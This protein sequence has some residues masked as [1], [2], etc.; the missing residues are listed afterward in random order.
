MIAE[1]ELDT[2]DSEIVEAFRSGNKMVLQQFYKSNYP[3]IAHFVI[4]NGGTDD[5]AKDIYQDA[6]I[7]IYERINERSLILNCRLKTYL[8]SVCRNLWLK[9]IHRKGKFTPHV[10]DT[11]EYIPPQEE[12]INEAEISLHYT[13]ISMAMLEIGEPCQSLLNG[14]YIHQLSMAEITEKFGYSNTDT[15]KNQK[16]KCMNRLKKIFFDIKNKRATE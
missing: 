5:E 6:I 2:K 10:E 11:E 15:A 14:F 1:I 3:M 13:I 16:Y 9:Q 7:A 12:T 4:S 8:Y